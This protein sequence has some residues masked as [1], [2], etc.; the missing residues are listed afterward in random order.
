MTTCFSLSRSSV[1]LDALVPLMDPQRTHFNK[2]CA[3]ISPSPTNPNRLVIQFV[4]GSTHEADV[5]IGADGIKSTVRDCIFNTA[6]A[7][8][9]KASTAAFSN[10]L[11]YRGMVPYSAIKA[12]GFKTVLT[13]RPVCFVGPNKVRGGK[14]QLSWQVILTPRNVIACHRV[15]HTAQRYRTLSLV[16]SRLP[17]L[18]RISV[19]PIEVG[20]AASSTNYDIPLGSQSLP[21]G[22]PWSD[23]VSRTDLQKEFEGWGS[24]VTTLMQFMPENPMRWYMHV[25]HPP[26]DSFA[27]GRVALLG[28]AVRRS[29]PKVE[30]GHTRLIRS[31]SQAHGMMPHL[32]AGAG[33]G[34]EDALL[35]MRLFANP[36]VNN[37]NIEVS[38]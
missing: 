34:L 24:D 28:D 12:A 22:T 9:A 33:Q 6:N 25:V 38:E 36:D 7:G 4:D 27:R 32:G 17:T 18:T 14:V 19:L 26:L 5:V 2:R 20:V 21:E 23:T 37:D 16:A 30:F 15:L 35:L 13:D 1:F 11:T 31:R 10:S 29:A 8:H 3:S